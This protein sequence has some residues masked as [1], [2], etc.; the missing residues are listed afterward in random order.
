MDKHLWIKTMLGFAQKSKKIV[1]GESAVKACLKKEKIYLL[2]IAEDL[3]DSRKKHW[4]YL[5]QDLRIPVLTIGSKF[6][7]GIALGQ[8]PR[9][10]IGITDRD[11]AR[12]ILTRG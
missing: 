7:L 2:I 11:L 5:A 8:S 6:E 12:T 4:E 9:S 3:S 10:V 1:S